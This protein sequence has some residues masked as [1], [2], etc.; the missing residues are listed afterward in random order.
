MVKNRRLVITR[1]K[2]N[3]GWIVET[4]YRTVADHWSNMSRTVTTTFPMKMVERVAERADF[5]IYLRLE[6]K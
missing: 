4:D 2:D 1:C 5:A 6:H 3:S